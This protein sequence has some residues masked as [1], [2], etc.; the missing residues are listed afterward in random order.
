[1]FVFVER[2]ALLV[3]CSLNR[4]IYVSLHVHN[5]IYVMN[6][7]R[8]DVKEIMA[9]TF[10]VALVFNLHVDLFGCGIVFVPV[11]LSN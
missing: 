11:I 7:S 10:A 8:K 3:A 4:N 5:F 6:M 2:F 1:M 9:I